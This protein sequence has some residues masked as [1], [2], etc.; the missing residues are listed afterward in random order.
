MT[1]AKDSAKILCKNIYFFPTVR[2]PQPLEVKQTTPLLADIIYVL[3][4][5][6]SSHRKPHT[7]TNHF[8]IR[9]EDLGIRFFLQR[10]SAEC[11][12]VV[13]IPH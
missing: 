11:S 10:I 1:A 9:T 6:G 13:I 2:Q 12:P 3:K 5:V 4:I 8:C 7:H